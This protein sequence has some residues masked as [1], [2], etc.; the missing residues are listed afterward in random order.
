MGAV[1]TVSKAIIH[2]L[3]QLLRRPEQLAGAIEAARADDDALVSEKDGARGGGGVAEGTASG[4]RD[5]RE[6]GTASPRFRTG[7]PSCPPFAGSSAP[8]PHPLALERLDG[9]WGN[10]DRNR[11]WG[12][13][14]TSVNV[15]E[16]KG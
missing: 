5:R 3:D 15:T 16:V 4:C 8:P 13:D 14:I 10:R 9:P 2:A 12:A 6:T 11:V 1:D 7:A